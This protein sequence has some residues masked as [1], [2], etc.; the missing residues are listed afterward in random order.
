VLTAQ[1]TIKAEKL[2]LSQIHMR[3]PY[4]VSRWWEKFLKNIYEYL[5]K[6]HVTKKLHGEESSLTRCYFFN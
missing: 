1:G 2:N 4:Y 5:F 6:L 3:V